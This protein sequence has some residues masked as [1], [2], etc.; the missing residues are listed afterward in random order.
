MYDRT[1]E[2]PTTGEMRELTFGVSGKLIMNVLVMYDRQTGTFWSQLLGKAVEGE[3]INAQL[4]P[5][6]ASQTTWGEWRKQF[7]NT[8]ALITNGRGRY[9]DSYDSYYTSGQAG[10]L[11]ESREDERLAAK[12]LISGI[13]LDGQPVAYPHARLAQET[14]VNDTIDG[15]DLTVWF[16]KQSATARLFERTV[17]TT[18][19]ATQTLTFRATGDDL[20]FIDEETGSTWLLFTGKAIDGPLKGTTLTAIPS[21]SSFWFGWKD[22]YPETLVYAEE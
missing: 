5:L 9:G 11:G 13:V 20:E 16:Q 10:V 7:P 8:K 15:T 14:V 12:E 21:T 19:G 4:T 1:V 6:A 22:W 2:D 17:E 3:M 18:S